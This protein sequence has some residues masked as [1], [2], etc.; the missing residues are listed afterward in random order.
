MFV[1]WLL[2]CLLRRLVV[3]VGVVAVV[4]V[5]VVPVSK[6]YSTVVPSILKEPK[7]TQKQTCNEISFNKKR[8]L[9]GTGGKS[10]RSVR[11]RR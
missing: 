3:V 10:V 5:G 7:K 2:A 8:S 11:P 1:C 4:V 6:P 9:R